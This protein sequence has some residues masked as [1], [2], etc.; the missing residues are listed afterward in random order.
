MQ[1][2][3]GHI[4]RQ[5]VEACVDERRALLCHVTSCGR[6]VQLQSAHRRHGRTA[7]VI[8][9]CPPSA[10]HCDDSDEGVRTSNYK[11]LFRDATRSTRDL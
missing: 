3:M 10:C 2:E 9:S 7:R 4:G 5:R 11:R 8:R 1:K 6:D